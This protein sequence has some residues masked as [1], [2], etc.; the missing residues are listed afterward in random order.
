MTTKF[1]IVAAQ[2]QG[3]LQTDR[4]LRRCM[5]FL[6]LACFSSSLLA[7]EVS[8]PSSKAIQAWISEL[9]HDEYDVRVAATEK[10]VQHP[11]QAI[12]ALKSRITGG[13]L[14]FTI[15]AIQ[16]LTRIAVSDTAANEQAQLAILNI[17]DTCVALC[18]FFTQSNQCGRAEKEHSKLA[19]QGSYPDL[20]RRGC[21][22]QWVA[23]IH[24]WR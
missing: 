1:H 15:R 5:F 16:V 20:P 3:M 19:R 13:T 2:R 4:I 22:R 8:V 6:V 24:V 18:A 14:E 12:I 11:E 23:R 21:S 17:S 10:L 7:D 9:D